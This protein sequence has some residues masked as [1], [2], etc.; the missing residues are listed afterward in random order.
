ME[1]YPWIVLLHIVGAFV[2]AV[3]HGVSTFAA[4]AIRAAKRD[5]GRVRTLVELS[6]SSLGAMYVGLVMLL[7][8]G[9]W[10]GMYAGYFARGWIWA[11][12]VVL[13]VVVAAMYLMG[14]RYYARV[15]QA[16]G[17]PSMVEKEPAG[18]AGPELLD[19]LLTNRVPEILMAIG[20]VGLLVLLWLMVVKPF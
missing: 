15:R 11:A 6:G 5:P 4:F 2:F 18:A 20:G 3:A 13:V 8:G 14:S 19:P 16:V 9:I 7:I 12:I 17:L 1:I 10:A